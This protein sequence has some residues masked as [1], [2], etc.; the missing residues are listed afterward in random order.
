MWLK[1]LSSPS[2]ADSPMPCTLQPPP[3]VYMVMLVTFDLGVFFKPGGLPNSS[4][5]RSGEPSAH[6]PEI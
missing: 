6:L 2:G 5:A 1:A 3:V 4:S